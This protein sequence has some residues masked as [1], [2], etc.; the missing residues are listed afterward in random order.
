MEM[1]MEKGHQ[2]YEL[3]GTVVSLSVV[4]SLTATWREL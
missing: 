3:L 1:E 4:P 2:N